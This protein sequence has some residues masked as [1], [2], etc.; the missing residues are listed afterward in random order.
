MKDR[1]IITITT[2]RKTH[3]RTLESSNEIYAIKTALA[4]HT[5]QEPADMSQ[6]ISITAV[7]ITEE[8]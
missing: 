8:N 5:M 2:E 4:F 1:Y 7:K 6:I 3:P